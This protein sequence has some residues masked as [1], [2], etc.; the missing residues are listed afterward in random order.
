MEKGFGWALLATFLYGLIDVVNRYAVTSFHANPWSFSFIQLLAGGVVLVLLAG[1]GR[2]S[3][4]T[5]QNPAS[6]A[7]G[8]LHIITML[9]YVLAMVTISATEMNFMSK[10]AVLFSILLAWGVQ[11]RR[12]SS[13]DY[14]GALIMLAGLAMLIWRQPE[15]LLTP[16]VIFVILGAFANALAAL[17]TERH[18]ESNKASGMRERCRYTGVIL[19][20]TSFALLIFMLGL[21]QLKVFGSM[22]P[23][24]LAVVVSQVPPPS[25]YFSGASVWA[26][27]I[28]GITLRAPVTYAMYYSIRLL[29]ADNFLM[30]LALIPFV[31]LL[32]ESLFG[33]FGLL[34]TTMISPVDIVA[35]L[36]ITTGSVLTVIMRLIRRHN[37]KIRQELEF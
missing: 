13:T 18:P 37:E 24:S 27:V 4:R 32:F 14:C 11:G 20:L 23:Q 29:K 5:L 6:W 36:V 31:A 7:I 25:E 1:V 3:H 30:I 26:A 10:S 19:A 22:L 9:M 2:T 15:G 35:G 21:S 34:D 8:F 16:A 28:V 12:P 33:V 17:L